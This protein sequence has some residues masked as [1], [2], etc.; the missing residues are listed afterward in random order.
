[1]LLY[2][3]SLAAQGQVYIVNIKQVNYINVISSES[4]K[5][6]V[7][8]LDQGD[9]T[10]KEKPRLPNDLHAVMSQSI[11]FCKIRFFF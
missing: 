11:T 5:N 8:I 7:T 9:K 2:H 10:W 6:A 4:L 3:L 1:M